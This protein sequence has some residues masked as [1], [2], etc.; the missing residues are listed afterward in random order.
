MID[1]LRTAK[2]V[3]QHPLGAPC[4]YHRCIRPGESGL[5]IKPLYSPGFINKLDSFEKWPGIVKSPEVK[6]LAEDEA[7]IHL[8]WPDLRLTKW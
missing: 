5:H 2:L 7:T 8:V 1:S 4:E 6:L 3:L